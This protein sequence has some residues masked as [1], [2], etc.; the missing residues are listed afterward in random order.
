MAAGATPQPEGSGYGVATVSASGLVSFSGAL[1]DGTK[2]T[3]GGPVAGSGGW[4]FYTRPYG[5]KG[6]LVGRVIFE[7]V[8][9]ISDAD[10]SALWAA[11][12]SGREPYSAGFQGV[13]NVIGSVYTAPSNGERILAF[14]NAE[15]NGQ[16]TATNGGLT[17]PF[18]KIV[19]LSASNTVAPLV[20]GPDKLKL[21]F[22]TGEEERVALEDGRRP[23]GQRLEFTRDRV[24]RDP[25]IFSPVRVHAPITGS[26]G[27]S[28]IP[29]GQTKVVAS[30][31]G[32]VFQKQNIAVGYFLNGGQSG[33]VLLTPA[34]V[35]ME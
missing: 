18:H 16:L 12:P 27:G 15:G 9:T 14:M 22:S 11:P 28:F 32:V 19:T 1:A 31:H 29:P 2:I 7:D 25:G 13:A 23:L 33:A 8:A 26:F 3:E 21:S 17:N 6:L 4:S 10:G 20:I 34:I 35:P 5:N 24:L 30:I